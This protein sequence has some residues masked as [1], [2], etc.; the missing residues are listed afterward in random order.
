MW[1]EKLSINRINDNSS[2]YMGKFLY[3]VVTTTTV[4]SGAMLFVIMAWITIHFG[5]NPRNGGSP[6][7]DNSFT[8]L[9]DVVGRRRTAILGEPAAS[10]VIVSFCV[11]VWCHIARNS[12]RCRSP[13]VSKK[14]KSLGQCFSTFVR[15]RPVNSFFIRRGPG[16]N[17]FTRKYFPILFK[18]IY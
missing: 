16:P 4:A 13:P 15:P 17:K 12:P 3:L 10:I 11:T 9:W 1:N 2:S 7:K 8:V 6:P 14:C 18:F 5:R